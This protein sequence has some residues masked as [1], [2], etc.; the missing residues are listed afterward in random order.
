MPDRASPLLPQRK[1]DAALFVLLMVFV[2]G[3]LISLFNFYTLPH[4]D[5]IQYQQAAFEIRQ[6]LPPTSYKI[7][8][9]FPL[10]IA[11]VSLVLPGDPLLLHSTQVVVML[12]ALFFLWAFAWFARQYLPVGWPFL[13]AIMVFNPYF[14]EFSLQTLMEMFLL[15]LVA[16]TLWSFSRR[17]DC[18]LAFSALAS[19]TRYDAVFLVPADGLARLLDSK[20][21]KKRWI[22]YLL[23]GLPCLLWLALS[24]R[25]S[26]VV[27]PY[28]AEILDP[29]RRF[30][31]W[32]MWRMLARM[33]IGQFPDGGTLHWPELA[34]AGAMGALIV[35]G[36]VRLW[37]RDRATTLVLGGFM[38][39]YLLVHAVFKAA[40]YRYNFPLLPWLYFLLFLAMEPEGP[41]EGRSA[42]APRWLLPLLLSTAGI[43]VYALSAGLWQA[44]HGR[45]LWGFA[46]V[47]LAAAVWRYGAVRQAGLVRPLMI[48]VAA[49]LCLWPALSRWEKSYLE[50]KW[51]FSEHLRVFQWANKHCQ[52][53]EKIVMVGSWYLGAVLPRPEIRGRFF[54][55]GWF[56]SDDVFGFID[57]YR[58][59]EE[60]SGVR[61][62]AWTSSLAGWNRNDWFSRRS[63]AFLL[64]ELGLD[65][66][67]SNP[68]FDLVGVVQSHPGHRAHVFRLRPLDEFWKVARIVDPN[69]SSLHAMQLGE[70]WSPRAEGRPGDQ[71]IWAVGTRSEVRLFLGEPARN[72]RL[73]LAACPYTRGV[74]ALQTLVVVMNGGKLGTL[75]LERRGREYTLPVPSRLVRRGENR[76]LFT[77][78]YCSVPAR[79]GVSGDTR[80]L[81]VSF[82]RV[83]FAYDPK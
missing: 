21:E 20:L 26:P 62:L 53:G 18:S 31:G 5:F 46:I 42:K 2:S 15:A 16:W 77:Y 83:E 65:R 79:L 51:R 63:R 3:I 58:S 7:M 36:G 74:E 47:F 75:E 33:L 4:N 24:I 10:A 59:L 6:L 67:V 39:G 60:R 49:L 54:D 44:A 64:N 55:A 12:A 41:A 27:N 19:V 56:S 32:P 11:A 13:M 1:S 71:F 29:A 35:S 8:P 78:A 80:S 23:A 52:P 82:K 22:V 48:W 17:R 9:L 66:P 45:W 61:Y 70:G 57:E 25:Y 81:A 76:I 40:L 43:S 34:L 73:K 50:Q 28:V 30:A 38:A 72:G 68:L 37:R 14:L 69:H